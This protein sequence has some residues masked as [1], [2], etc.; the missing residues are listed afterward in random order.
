MKMKDDDFKVRK[1]SNGY[2][3]LSCADNSETIF[4]TAKDMGKWFADLDKKTETPAP[5]E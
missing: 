4:A 3:V 1:V 2:I 5:T